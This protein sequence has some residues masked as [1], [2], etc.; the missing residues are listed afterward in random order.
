MVASTAGL[1]ERK[2]ITFSKYHLYILQYLVMNVLIANTAEAWGIAVTR[3]V[4]YH[5]S[6]SLIFSGTSQY[7]KFTVTNRM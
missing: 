3:E 2:H 7:R 1:C 4:L 6:I 5:L